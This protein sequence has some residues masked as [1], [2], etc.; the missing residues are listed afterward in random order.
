M[1]LNDGPPLM[2]VS[3][4]ALVSLL[5]LAI[6]LSG[7]TTAGSR[8]LD[9][10]LAAPRPAPIHEASSREASGRAGHGSS[11]DMDGLIHKYAA[12]Y[13][14][15]ESLIRRVI[16]RES[17][18]NPKARNGP[19]WGLMQIRHDTATVMGYSG[20][21]TGLLDP[22][23]NLRYA[24]KYLHGAFLVAGGN[25]DRAVHLYASGY[26]YDAKRKGMLKEAGFR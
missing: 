16:V 12:L 3:R 2:I 22:E 1:Y 10:A 15:P 19:Y 25:P 18:Y 9:T 6:P 20:S 24:G 5:A 23:T 8:T 26:Y 11:A 4:V 17:G 21:A 14:M 7:C 13:D